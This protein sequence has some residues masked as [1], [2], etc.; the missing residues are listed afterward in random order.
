MYVYICIQ[1]DLL[2]TQRG[3]LRDERS[4]WDHKRSQKLENMPNPSLSNVAVM[5]DFLSTPI[6]VKTL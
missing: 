5:N 1:T 4:V 6:L 3:F 2:R